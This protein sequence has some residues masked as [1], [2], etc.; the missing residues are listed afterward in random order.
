MPYASSAAER[1]ASLQRECQTLQDAALEL[2]ARLSG[3]RMELCVARGE[4]DDARAHMQAMYVAI[5]QRY[6]AR[7][8]GQQ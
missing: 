5:Q 7:H 3:K 1:I 4:H 2:E 6:A 8:Q